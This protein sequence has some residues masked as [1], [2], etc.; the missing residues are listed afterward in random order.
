MFRWSDSATG[1]V[2]I[3]ITN[4]HGDVLG[5][6]ASNL[7]ADPGILATFETDEYG[8]P[9]DSGAIGYVRYGY[10]GEHQRAADNPAGITLMGVRP[11][12]PA[13]GRFLT[14]DPI[15]GGSA[16]S[17]DYCFADPINC[18]DLDGRMA[19]LALVAGL[20]L[21]LSPGQVAPPDRRGRPGRTRRIRCLAR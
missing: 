16:G 11:H 13:T 4:L 8:N 14:V 18:V 15:Q 6:A 7:A 21:G 5:V 10:L 20:G 9:R 12:N 17:Y 2:R 19:P 1:N 3:Q